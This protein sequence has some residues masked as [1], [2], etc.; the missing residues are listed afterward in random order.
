MGDSVVVSKRGQTVFGN[1]RSTIPADQ[2]GLHELTEKAVAARIRGVA[3]KP[4]GA[5]RRR[6]A[7]A[8][9][10]PRADRPLA[11]PILKDWAA[12]EAIRLGKSEGIDALALIVPDSVKEYGTGEWIRGFALFV[13]SAFG[14]ES[15]AVAAHQQLHLY[16]A[17]TGRRISMG[18]ATHATALKADAWRQPASAPVREAFAATIEKN[19]EKLVRGARLD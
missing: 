15:G 8:V 13:F 7:D 3:V 17:R 14:R 2:L 5:Q 10:N 19:S 4:L 16:D 18:F 1:D 12:N 11:E 9:W 6:I